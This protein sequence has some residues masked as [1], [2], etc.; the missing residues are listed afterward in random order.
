MILLAAILL[1]CVYAGAIYLAI[2]KGNVRQDL[3]SPAVVVTL[4]HFVTTVPFLLM[5]AVNPK[6]LPEV[7]RGHRDLPDLDLA[8]LWYAIVQSLGFIALYLGL[9]NRMAPYIAGSLPQ[10]DNPVR[11][12]RYWIAIGAAVTVGSIGFVMFVEKIG[13]LRVLLTNMTRRSELMAGNHY[14]LS[15]DVLLSI[16]AGLALYSF[17]HGKSLLRA[18][19]VLMLFLLAAALYSSNG[20]RYATVL[21]AIL[22]VNTWHY[23]IGRFRR[24]TWK[25]I[26]IPALL[27]PFIVLMPLLRNSASGHGGQELTNPVEQVSSALFDPEQGIFRQISYTHQHILIYSHFR[28]DNLWWGLSYRDLLAM[29]IPRSM[30]PEKP[31]GDDGVY[32]SDIA[33]GGDPEPGTAASRLYPDA[34]PPETIG[35]MYMNF[36]VPGVILGMYLLGSIYAVGYEYMRRTGYSF[37]SIFVYTVLINQF[38]LSNLRIA[39]VAMDLTLV[40]IFWALFFGFRFVRSA[41]RSSRLTAQALAGSRGLARRE[42]GGTS[43]PAA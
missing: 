38:H 43:A 30:M 29:P 12:V 37:F 7:L 31:P 2:W 32:V 26:A 20:T 35:I 39:Q 42:P 27:V 18:T 21:L 17:R 23:G 41:S 9:T 8:V 4:G 25:L 3:L 19:A 24:V 28:P 13:G 33:F 1:T 11:P 6:T 15:L 16:A 5:L 34:W 40:S 14:A 22:L 10:S 36:W